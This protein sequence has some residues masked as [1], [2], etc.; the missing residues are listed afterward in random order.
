MS[1]LLEINSRLK[2]IKADIKLLEAERDGLL[3]AKALLENVGNI[4]LA[5][6][7]KNAKGAT[8]AVKLPYGHLKTMVASYIDNQNRTVEE[9]AELAKIPT[10][11][12]RSALQQLVESNQIIREGSR[13]HYTYR[14]K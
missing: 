12:A 13:R 1:V 2:K 14:S 6:M 8:Q 3:K 4:K 11:Q 5:T 7:N 9:I 10:Q